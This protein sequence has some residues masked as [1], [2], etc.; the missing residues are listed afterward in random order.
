MVT[1][2]KIDPLDRE[3]IALAEIP[4]GLEKLSGRHVRGKI[5]AR[6]LG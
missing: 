6:I 3:I 5:V 4:A 2:G 1:A